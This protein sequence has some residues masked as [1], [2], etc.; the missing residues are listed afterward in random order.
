LFKP[1][2]SRKPVSASCRYEVRGGCRTRTR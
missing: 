2:G 1:R